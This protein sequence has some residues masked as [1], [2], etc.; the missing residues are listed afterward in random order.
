MYD[1]DPSD[2][3][4]IVGGDESRFWSS[5]AGAYVAELPEG[6]GVT[7]IANEFELIDVLVGAGLPGN[8]PPMPPAAERLAALA[9]IDRAKV[10]AAGFTNDE[11]AGRAS[12]ADDDVRFDTAATATGVKIETDDARMERRLKALEGKQ[13]LSRT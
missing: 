4:W 5:Q 2:W 6:A 9:H 3:Y 12:V 10:R 13:S 7:R 11:I 1:Y 8:A